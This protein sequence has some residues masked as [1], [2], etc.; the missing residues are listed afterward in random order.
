[1]IRNEQVEQVI[2]EVVKT[3]GAPST[4]ELCRGVNR[5]HCASRASIRQSLKYLD[6]AGVVRR[7]GGDAWKIQ[8]EANVTSSSS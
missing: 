3:R 5:T 6:G 7:V 1:M 2:L 4:S 8:G